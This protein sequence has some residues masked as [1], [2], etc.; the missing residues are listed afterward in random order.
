MERAISVKGGGLIEERL[1]ASSNA[2]HSI[3]YSILSSPLPVKNYTATFTLIPAGKET[4]VVWQARFDATGAPDAEARKV[5]S[6]IF[7]SGFDGMKQK[8]AK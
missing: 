2:K 8:L 7:T 6:G 4:K 3:T 1:L 5:I